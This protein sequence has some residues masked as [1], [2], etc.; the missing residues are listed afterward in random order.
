MNSLIIVIVVAL[1][2][3]VGL[4]ILRKTA[5]PSD[6]AAAEDV[7]ALR[8][9][10]LL[11]SEVK[12]YNQGQVAEGRNS[13]DLYRRLRKDVDRARRMYEERVAEGAGRRADYFHDELVKEL[14]GGDASALGVDYQ[15][16][17]R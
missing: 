6:S 16:S 9:A 10:K 1:F 5:A 13:K 11:V 4:L 2:I 7:D 12:L 3:L 17:R 15:R 8:F 14:A